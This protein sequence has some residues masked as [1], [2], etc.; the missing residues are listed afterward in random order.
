MKQILM[1]LIALGISQSAFA[2]KVTLRGVPLSV[3]LV[4]GQSF[5]S[6]M[7]LAL[8]LW[9]GEKKVLVSGSSRNLASMAQIVALIQAEI[10]DNDDQ[11]IELQCTRRPFAGNGGETQLP[12]AVNHRITSL[13]IEDYVFKGKTWTLN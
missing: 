11:E 5:D 8:V 2:Q 4:A 12:G 7:Q 9:D 3:C 13:Q 6:S 1:V 10:S